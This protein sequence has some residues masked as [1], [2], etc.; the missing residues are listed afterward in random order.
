M[1]EKFLFSMF[2]VYKL[3]IDILP[4]E[5]GKNSMSIAAAKFLS[6]HIGI[7]ETNVCSFWTLKNVTKQTNGPT[8]IRIDRPIDRQCKI[9]VIRICITKNCKYSQKWKIN[10]R[11]SMLRRVEGKNSNSK[12]FKKS[13][14]KRFTML[15]YSFLLQ[16]FILTFTN[17][18]TRI[19][20]FL[21]KSIN[22]TFSQD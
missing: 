10:Q 15:F 2:I 8:Y 16:R 3:P 17:L 11:F 1:E 5:Y 14:R 21:L 4:L 18:C 7:Y 19:T 20:D 9:L 6:G 13:Q 22:P 12:T